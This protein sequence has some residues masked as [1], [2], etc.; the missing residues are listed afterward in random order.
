MNN[1]PVEASVLIL[2][3]WRLVYNYYPV[4]VSV[5]ILVVWRLVYE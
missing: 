5:L 4:E 3:V 1:Y 2:V